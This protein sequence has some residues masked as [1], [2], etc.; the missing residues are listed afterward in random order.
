M[1]KY[2]MRSKEVTM[3]GQG[4]RW[5]RF[6]GCVMLVCGA[7]LLADLRPSFAEELSESQILNALKSRGARSLTASPAERTRIDE[8]RRFLDSLRNRTAR[9]LTLE[10]RDT[11]TRVSVDKP[12]VDIEINFDYNSDI[13]GPQALKPLLRLGRALSDDTLKGTIFFIQGH[14]D[15]KGSD[16]YNQELSDRRAEAI[17]HLLIE[18]FKLPADTLIAA[19]FGKTQLKNKDNPFADENRRVQI[20]NTEQN[21]TANAR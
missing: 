2:S 4:Q 20:V 13:V 18:E 12:R 15:A 16:K 9:S 10:E 7:V 14:T 21:A 5:R 11:M 1:T 6:F 3:E 19:G 8:E 17:K